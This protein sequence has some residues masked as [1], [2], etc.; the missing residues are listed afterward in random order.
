[1]KHFFVALVIVEGD[2]W[3]S[4]V[5][6]ESKWEYWVVY[7]HDLRLV[8]LSWVEDAQIFDVVAVGSEHAVLPVETMLDE[9]L[10]WVYVVKDGIGVGLMAGCE[11]D[12]LVV[13]A[14]LLQALHDVR[15]DIDSSVYWLFIRKINFQN[16]I[17]FLFLNIINTMNQSLIHIKNC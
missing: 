11:N 10:F 4:V 1:M 15:S 17:S 8:E 5:D 7:Y 16:N 9:L 6:L 12:D 2:D 14:G 13:L 3:D